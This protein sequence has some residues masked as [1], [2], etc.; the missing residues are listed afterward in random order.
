MTLSAGE[1]TRGPL[2]L[3]GGPSSYN[4]S[5]SPQLPS[6]SWTPERWGAGLQGGGRL[7][8]LLLHAPPSPG[9]A[10]RA[11]EEPWVAAG[12]QAGEGP[13]SLGDVCTRSGPWSLPRGSFRGQGPSWE[14]RA[15]LLPAAWAPPG[16]R[17]EGAAGSVCLLVSPPL[18]SGAKELVA[19]P[20]PGSVWNPLCPSGLLAFQLRGRGPSISTLGGEQGAAE[21]GSG[22]RLPR[23]LGPLH[24]HRVELPEAHTGEHSMKEETSVIEAETVPDSRVTE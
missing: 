4:P 15:A 14:C 2:Q 21:G 9:Q 12:P 1:G 20:G 24:V 23:A 3:W 8:G 13:P 16:S 18:V 7:Q 17:G 11:L 6:G 10:S 5:A 19:W 22:V